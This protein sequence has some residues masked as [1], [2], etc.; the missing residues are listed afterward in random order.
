[1]HYTIC[2][3]LLSNK[4]NNERGIIGWRNLKGKK[5]K[6]VKRGPADIYWNGIKRY[7]IFGNENL[8]L[9]GYVKLFVEMKKKNKGYILNIGSVAGFLPG[10]LMTEYYATKSYVL[11]LTQG[12]NKELKNLLEENN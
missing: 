5:K 6:W 11:R 7:G 10:P 1:M 8:T 4:T 3:N 12:I 2:C 9:K